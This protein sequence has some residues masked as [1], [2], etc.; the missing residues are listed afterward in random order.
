MNKTFNTLF[1]VVS[2]EWAP[3]IKIKMLKYIIIL[4]LYFKLLNRK[5]LLLT[6]GCN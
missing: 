4:K 2:Q 1:T 6:D 5:K 3:I